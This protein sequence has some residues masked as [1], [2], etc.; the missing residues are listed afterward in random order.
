MRFKE[1]CISVSATMAV[2]LT[3]QVRAQTN[4]L[5][6]AT[7]SDEELTEFK[8]SNSIDTLQ[9]D[10]QMI[11][12]ISDTVRFIPG[13][14]VNDNGDR[15][16][17]SGFNIR[18]VEADAIAITIDGVTQGETLSPPSFAPYGMFGSNRNVVEL[19]T[20]KAIEIVKGP[21]SISAGSGALGGSVE[22]TTKDPGDVLA[23]GETFGGT[24]KSGYDSRN[25]ETL[26]TGT[27]AGRLGNLESIVVLTRRD[28]S[29][30]SAHDSGADILGPS[31]GQADPYD[32]KTTSLLAKLAY[33]LSD[34]QRIG[35]VIENIERDTIGQP[36]S[37]DSSTYYDFNTTDSFERQRIGAFFEMENANA[38]LFDDLEITF[39]DQEVFSRG[40]TAFAFDSRFDRDP[41]N[42][43]LRNEDRSYVQDTLNLTADLFKSF[44]TGNVNHE[45][46]YG[47][48]WQT[49][50]VKNELFDRRFASVSSTSAQTQNLRDPS[51]VPETERTTLT[52]YLQDTLNLTDKFSLNPGIRYDNTE[53]EASVDENFVDV[54]GNSVSD[55]EFTSTVFQLAAEYQIAP[56]HSLVASFGQGYK[57]PTT[58]QLYLDTNSGQPGGLID[59]ITNASFDDWNVLA[60]P[61]LDAE[62][63]VNLEFSYLWETDRARAKLTYFTADYENMIQNVTFTRSLGQ[64]IF[65]APSCGR[66]GCTAPVTTSVDQ[67]SV[68]QNVGEVSVD[69]WEFESFF[70]FD[71]N[72]SVSLALSMIDGEHETPLVNQHNAGDDL[73]TISPNNMVLG[74]TY[75]SSDQKW[76]LSAYANWTDSKD[77]SKDLSFTALNNTSG[78]ALFTDSWLVVDII[79]Y[80]NV[81][82]KFLVTASINNLFDEDYIRWEVVNSVRTGDGGFFSG[83]RGTGIDRFSDPG[84]NASLNLSYG[85]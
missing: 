30:S 24:V 85:F 21:N 12:N 49:I 20:V 6:T 16:N 26:L 35:L 40:Q 76:G 17:D 1:L 44:S 84:R 32:L 47:L 19:E 14:Q 9:I 18:G 72:L 82:E 29:E 53:Y 33:N 65:I 69:G 79:G 5:E 45:L 67:Y 70:A 22:Y 57:A 8:N 38:L 55:A 83:V 56:N 48:T 52:F 73:V 31:R 68:A 66:F 15:Y 39:D 78:P 37:R 81:T 63:S 28:T 13:V 34:N 23:R 11:Y 7:V 3:M 10:R 43:I 4:E 75:A 41:S 42:D 2:L 60:N 62:E 51:W 27:L 50:D 80:F 46:N 36:L 59:S 71:Q 64:E 54:I 74:A 77:D 58:Q 25:G 61:E